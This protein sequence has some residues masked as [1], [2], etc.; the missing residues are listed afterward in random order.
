MPVCSCGQAMAS[1]SDI[2]SYIKR[3]LASEIR[4]PWILTPEIVLA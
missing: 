2:S 1:I 3:R 4:L